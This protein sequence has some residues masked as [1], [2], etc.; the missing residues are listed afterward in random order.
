[1]VLGVISGTA[2]SFGLFFLLL[3]WLALMAST[4]D[5]EVSL[6]TLIQ[7][8]K[9]QRQKEKK[10]TAKKEKKVE[11]APK[12]GQQPPKSPK[13]PR[14]A[15]VR[16]FSAPGSW[17]GQSPFSSPVQKQSPSKTEAGRKEKNLQTI[18]EKR[19]QQ[20]KQKIQAQRFVPPTV[21]CTLL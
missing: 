13:S 20:V 5:L 14:A 7:K 18:R 12:A 19:N 15:P 16:A 2:G 11:V 6:D 10:E 17:K 1:L 4:T 3:H 8:E 21:T 9:K